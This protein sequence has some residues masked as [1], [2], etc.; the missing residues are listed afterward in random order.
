MLIES[1]SQAILKW[2]RVPPGTA[3]RHTS[4]TS[5]TSSYTDGTNE[6][7]D[8]ILDITTSDVCPGEVPLSLDF[9]SDSIP[10]DIK[11]TLSSLVDELNSV[12]K[13]VAK[14]LLR[15]GFS[16]WEVSKNQDGDPVILPY[17]EEVLFYLTKDKSVVVVNSETNEQVVGLLSFLNYDRDS[18]TKV[19][20]S[21]IAK[22]RPYVKDLKFKIEPTPI[23]LKNASKVITALTNC[24]LS[25]ARYRALLRPIRFANV[26]IGTALGDEQT[27]TIDGISAAINANS[28][29]LANSSFINEF[30]DNLAVL[31]NRKGLGKVELSSDVPNAN[32]S[33]LAD[34]DY[35]L[36]K[37][38]LC[39]RFPQTYID[40][41]KSLNE[42]AVSML[43]GD[44]RYYKMCSECR[45]LITSTLTDWI[46]GSVFGQFMPY[47]FLTTLPSSEDSDVID[48]L[49]NY[50]DI[51]SRVEEFIMGSEETTEIGPKIHRL[52]LLKS[53]YGNSTNSPILLQWFDEYEAYLTMLPLQEQ[54]D[55]DIEGANESSNDFGS[56]DFGS[57]EGSSEG[58]SD[59]TDESTDLSD[60]SQSD[61]SSGDVEFFPTA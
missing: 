13:Q 46:R 1:F 39:M 21:S 52:Q 6:Y 47:F 3:L 22:D 2:L 56:N 33:E 25:I 44:L 30:D 29:S 15:S 55:K 19:E 38:T 35:W 11:D 9:E 36:K 61:I 27:E 31:P 49:T 12:I 45:T 59:Y 41:S 18:L 17:I 7:I 50:T 40:F 32:L 14:D 51:A 43:R 24:E 5:T 10:G 37:L 8:A 42:S 26:D 58:S 54:L 57:S 34:L 16:L 60:V 23:Q 48:A 20:L 28:E 53:L 4:G